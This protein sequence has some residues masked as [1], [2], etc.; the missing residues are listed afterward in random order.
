VIELDAYVSAISAGD[1]DAF[2]SWVA[3]AEPRIRGSLASF[4]A[5]VDTEAV[6]QECLLRIWQVAPRFEPD[7]RPDG[8]VRLA[9]RIARN[10][11]I[12]ELR[13]RRVE[14]ADLATLER[15][16]EQLQVPAYEPDP[17][18]REVIRECR[19]K[20]PDKPRRA[21]AS[22]LAGD[23]RPDRALAAD[24]GMKLNTFL[25]NIRRARLGLAECL[26]RHGVRVGG[27]S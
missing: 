15:A 23:G 19:E 10:L 5:R 13:R 24:L 11:A 6:V 17:F 1:P 14:P 12:T 20:L 2:A 9:V 16:A 22:R 25:Q 26:R 18:L 7:G 3:G 27:E 8:L 21:L 4:A